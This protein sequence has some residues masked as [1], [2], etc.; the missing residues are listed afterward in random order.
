MNLEHMR[1]IA[2]RQSYHDMHRML[3]PIFTLL[4]KIFRFNLELFISTFKRFHSNVSKDYI[5]PPTKDL[6][7]ILHWSDYLHDY[8]I[9]VGHPHSMEA[10]LR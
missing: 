2:L 7:V 6:S 8:Q 4:Y 9:I 10:S 3:R 1:K 5:P